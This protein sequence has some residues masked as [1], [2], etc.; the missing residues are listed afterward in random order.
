[1]MS[2]MSPET[3]AA[4]SA[5]MGMSITPEMAKMAMESMKNMKPEDMQRMVR[6]PRRRRRP[7]AH[8]VANTCPACLTL[9]VSKVPLD[10]RC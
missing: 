7:I 4:M 8:L 5:S 2:S 6:Q 1:M 10:F 3:M 9:V